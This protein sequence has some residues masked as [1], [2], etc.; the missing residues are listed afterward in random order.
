MSKR[1]AVEYMYHEGYSAEDAYDKLWPKYEEI[2]L[3]WIQE[4]YE[5]LSN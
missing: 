1:A 4:V 2:T 5:E 3:E